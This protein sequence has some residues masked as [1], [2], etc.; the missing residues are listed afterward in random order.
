MTNIEHVVDVRCYGIMGYPMSE[1]VCTCGEKKAYWYY[2]AK[3]QG[4]VSDY[5]A[6]EDWRMTHENDTER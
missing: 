4:F 1:A 2:E 6:I 3:R 5:A